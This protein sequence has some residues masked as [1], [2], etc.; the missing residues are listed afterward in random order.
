MGLA[1]KLIHT[2]SWDILDTPLHWYLHRQKCW[3][4]LH[5]LNPTIDACVDVPWKYEYVHYNSLKVNS[6]THLQS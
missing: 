2:E 1:C 5:E 4:E 6:C 3:L